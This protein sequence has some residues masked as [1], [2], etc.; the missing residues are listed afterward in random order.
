[1]ADNRAR[2]G[3]T[4]AVAQ[5]RRRR[6]DFSGGQAQRLPIPPEVEER[7]KAEGRTPRWVNDEGNRIYRLTKLDDYDPVEGV[8]PVPIGTDKDGRPIKA[9][10]LSKPTAFLEEDRAKAEDRR[11]SVERSLLKGQVPAA[12]GQAPA[13]VGGVNGAE[14]Y[15]DG[16][17][18]I[19]RGNQ[20]LD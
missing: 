14:M 2:Q 6:D 9:H 7:L 15:V 1:M 3:R 8:E 10:L 16:A 17:A 19:S 12:P 11:K 13:P 4:E 20:I 5:E 18:S